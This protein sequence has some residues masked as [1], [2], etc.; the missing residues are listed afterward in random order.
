MEIGRKGKGTNLFL[1]TD[2]N[3]LPLGVHQAGAD[4]HESTQVIP[5]I[6]RAVISWGCWP[7]SVRLLY[8]K[9]ADSDPLRKR[10]RSRCIRLICPPRDNRKVKKPLTASQRKWYSH[11]W[12][13]ERS[14]SWLQKFRRLIVRYEYHADLFLGMAQLACLFTMIQ[15]F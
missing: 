14:I 6:D 12:Q 8:D 15:R 13:I 3:N 7:R 2:G 10:L 11:R 9:A 1:L 4:R 5:L